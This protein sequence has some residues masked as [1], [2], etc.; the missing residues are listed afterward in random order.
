MSKLKIKNGT[1][2]GHANLCQRCS[3]G[4]YI[5]GYRESDR[6]VICN[7]CT[8][9]MVVP[10]AVLECTCFDDKHRPDW[11]QMQKLAIDIQPVRV[12]SRTSGFSVLTETR[13]VSVPDEDE[14][15]GEAAL[16]HK[17]SE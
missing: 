6:L 3:W 8:P 10:F 7:R 1:P 4:Q 14:F 13:E 5:A 15:E 11:Q 9:A 2:V 12:S 17:T 16:G